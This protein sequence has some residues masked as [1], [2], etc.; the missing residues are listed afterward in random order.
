MRVLL[1]SL[2]VVSLHA[3]ARDDVPLGTD[4]SPADSSNGGADATG[5]TPEA[6]AN[7][8]D[9]NTSGD[10]A[11]NGPDANDGGGNTSGG[12]SGMCAAA[13]CDMPMDGGELKSDVDG[14]A[15][16]I[17]GRGHAFVRVSAKDGM[18]AANAVGGVRA[19]LTATE[20]NY[21]LYAYGGR[22]SAACDDLSIASTEPAGETD[23]VAPTWS[24]EGLNPAGVNWTLTFEVR[25]ADGSCDGTWML[26]LEG[27]PCP[28]F[29]PV[30][31]AQCP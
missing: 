29:T 18:A 16:T 13:S 15:K 6:D 9:M 26:V 24:T 2:L 23:T 14:P 31:P 27:N 8:G 21:D 1:C 30:V 17:T 10:N 3:C 28:R 11:G 19:T 7:N 20:G 12:S 25:P 22:N 4:N 5:G